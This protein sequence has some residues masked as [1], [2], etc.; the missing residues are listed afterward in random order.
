MAFLNKAVLSVYKFD[1]SAT[2]LL[3]QLVFTVVLLNVLKA[4]GFLPFEDFSI[5]DA[6]RVRFS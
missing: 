2:I 3:L 1:H 5:A 6:K 4:L